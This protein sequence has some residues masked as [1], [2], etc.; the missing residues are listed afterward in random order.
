MV[1][2]ALERMVYAAEH[3]PE[4]ES[5]NEENNKNLGKQVEDAYK[6]LKAACLPML[7][8]YMQPQRYLKPFLGE[9]VRFVSE[10][11]Q[12]FEKYR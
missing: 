2:A 11:F 4:G 8:G 5:S 10:Y 12:A 1:H 6:Y 7:E 3:T 9:V